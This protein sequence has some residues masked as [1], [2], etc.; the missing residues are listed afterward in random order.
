[1]SLACARDET[2]LVGTIRSTLLGLASWAIPFIASFLFFSRTGELTVP[3]ELFKSLMVLTGGASGAVL[4]IAAFRNVTPNVRSGIALGFYWLGIN[5][6]LDLGTLVA[7]MHMDVN[8]YFIDIGLRYVM[9][10]IMAAAMGVI[11]AQERRR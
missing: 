8:L 2:K 10:P 1:M 5:I 3:R 7:V 11:G 9:L 4:L 6:A